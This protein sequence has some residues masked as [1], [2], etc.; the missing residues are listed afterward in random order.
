[1]TLR[2]EVVSLLET[3]WNAGGLTQWSDCYKLI[4]EQDGLGE[5]LEEGL[6]ASK[7]AM[8]A[9]KKAMGTA[10]G[11]TKKKT[12]KLM[13]TAKKAMKTFQGPR[14]HDCG[15]SASS[16]Y[17]CSRALHEGY[18]AGGRHVLSRTSTASEHPSSARSWVEVCIHCPYKYSYLD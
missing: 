14:P 11:C 13:G 8:Q 16:T 2:D 9:A 17:Y 18:C 4:E 7:K 1:M 6:E 10:D 15:W 12:M 5:A 3:E